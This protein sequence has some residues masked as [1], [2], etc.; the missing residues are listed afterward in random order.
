MFHYKIKKLG[1]YGLVTLSIGCAGR[2][3]EIYMHNNK[4]YHNQANTIP[5]SHEYIE[6]S[7]VNRLKNLN[8][9]EEDDSYNTF[10]IVENVVYSSYENL[11]KSLVNQN[12]WAFHSIE[13]KIWKEIFTLIFSDIIC[14]NSKIDLKAWE[15]KTEEEKIKKEILT[16]GNTIISDFIKILNFDALHYYLYFAYYIWCE[17][18]LSEP[19]KIDERF[20]YILNNYKDIIIHLINT[21]IYNSGY[22]EAFDNE[23]IMRLIEAITS[24]FSKIIFPSLQKTLIDVVTKKPYIIL[25]NNYPITQINIPLDSILA[26]FNNLLPSEFKKNIIIILLQKI[27]SWEKVKKNNTQESTNENSV[28]VDIKKLNETLTNLYI[29]YL[30]EYLE[31]HY[32]D[33]ETHY[34]KNR[35]PEDRKE[36]INHSLYGYPKEEAPE[37][38]KSSD[39]ENEQRGGGF[40]SNIFGKK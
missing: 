14:R 30:K 27:I 10:T 24:I 26:S 21:C 34:E 28:E 12:G 33:L 29:K 18:E 4:N 31:K 9:K 5:N 36:F 3:G 19:K 22:K 7:I 17:G 40:F 39:P 16:L 38:K 32:K 20:V 11:I 25:N 15:P 8:L 37:V 13:E 1:V 23:E 2:E 35:L 6:N